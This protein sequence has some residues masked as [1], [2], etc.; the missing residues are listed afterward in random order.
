MKQRF[1]I[2]FIENEANGEV[3][4]AHIIKGNDL[5]DIIVQFEQVV[6]EIKQ[7]NENTGSNNGQ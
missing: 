2:I 1:E 6:K 5:E 4:T 3:Q 7:D